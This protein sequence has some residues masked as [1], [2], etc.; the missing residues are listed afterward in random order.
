MPYQEA[1]MQLSTTLRKLTDR[2]SIIRKFVLLSGVMALSLVL[3]AVVAA[4]IQYLDLLETRK[5]YVKNQVETGASIIEQYQRKVSNNE[6]STEQAKAQVTSV[7]AG[8]RTN[9]GHDYYFIVDPQ[10]R[11][12]LHPSRKTG[13]DM[14]D[15][16]SDA[17]EYV[18][19]DIRETITRGDGFTQ[20]HSPKPGAEGQKTKISYSHAIKDWGWILSMGVYADDIEQQAWKFTG[21]LTLIGALT[22]FV[23]VVLC[24]LIVRS[25]VIPLQLAT[26]TAQA[27]ASG[28]FDSPIR[29]HSNDETGQ[30]LTS[31]NQMQDQLQRFNLEIQTMIRLQQG[32]DI[33]HRIPEDFPGDY[34]TLARGVNTVVFEHLQ[35]INEALDVMDEY[36]QGN[37]QRNMRRLSGQRARMHESLD[38]VKTNLSAINGEIAHLADAAAHGD[39]SARG[40]PSLYHYA[41]AEMVQALNRLMQHADAGLADIGRVVAA[42]ADGDLSQRVV[43]RHHGA[44]GQLA[45]STNRTADKLTDIVRDILQSTHSIDTAAGEI[46]TGNA[47][48]SR[49]T[50]S[51]AANLEETAA[52]MEELT[53]TVCQNAEN[54]RQ[55]NQL[56]NAAGE[57]ARNGGQVVEQVVTTMASIQQ[58][59]ARIADIIGVIDGIAFQTNILALNAAVEAARAGDHGRGF[60]VVASEVRALAQRSSSAAKEIKQLID[61]SADRVGQGTALVSDAGNT[62][63]NVVAAVQRVTAIIAEISAASQEQSSGIQQVNQTVIQLDETTQQNAALVEE[64]TAATCRLEQQ[65]QQLTTAVAVFRLEAESVHEFMPAA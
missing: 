11:I 23:V 6:L 46:A 39:F 30:L 13:T 5:Q 29:I 42:I 57:A 55:A 36:S 64:A 53:S 59:S 63:T 58:A 2:N 3:L 33:S 25:I 8:V 56:A 16:R 24:A 4:R 19:R 26:E 48:L 49:R 43:T 35:A 7:L 27:I 50:E 54:A 65:A 47:D 37:L 9:G 40:N 34:G 17:G 21:M 32:E 31:M 10:M 60:A 20:Y 12:V 28:C 18:Y 38:T 45:A 15:Y 61:D 41:F 14:N 52:S 44:F 51:Q 62:M 1:P 22:I